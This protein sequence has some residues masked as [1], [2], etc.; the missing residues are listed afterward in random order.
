MIGFRIN[1]VLSGKGD[2][3]CGNT[4]VSGDCEL[5]ARRKTV[6]NSK[7]GPKSLPLLSG[8]HRAGVIGQFLSWLC[9]QVAV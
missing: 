9:L 6:M 3:G 4:E 5:R 1:G 7:A 2:E 8:G